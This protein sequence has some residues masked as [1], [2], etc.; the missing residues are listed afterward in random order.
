MVLQSTTLNSY[1]LEK[2]TTFSRI[3]LGDFSADV[4][5]DGRKTLIFTPVDAFD[6][7]LD[8][9]VLKK[10]FANGFAGIGSQ[11][12]ASID[13]IASNTLGIS[14]VGTATSEK[15]VYEFNDAD[16]NGAFASFEIADR[17]NN[18]NVS[19]VEGCY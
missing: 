13:L 15:V 6:T 17:F 8:I 11:A 10:T 5:T 2:N 12:I 4:A 1:L 16:F 3:K 14:S 9:K 19:F 18:S 7:D